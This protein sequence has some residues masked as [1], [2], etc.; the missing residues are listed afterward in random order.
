MARMNQKKAKDADPKVHKELEGFDI[1]INSFGEIN[2]SFDIA[3]LNKFLDTNVEDKK[4]VVR[5]DYQ[6]PRV[7]YKKPEDVQDD[8]PY[9]IE[10]ST[11]DD[12]DDVPPPPPIGAVEEED[13]DLPA[14]LPGTKPAT[15]EPDPE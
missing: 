10:D 6:G 14:L 12:D 4:L 9:I 3:K 1:Q 5:D 7:K 8:E 2:T 11:E 15:H 13:I